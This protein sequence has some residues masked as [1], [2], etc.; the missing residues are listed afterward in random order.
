MATDSNEI[1]PAAGKMRAIVQDHYGETAEVLRLE[2]IDRPQIGDDDVLVRVRAASVHIGDWH[3]MSGL[4]YLLRVVGFGFRAPKVRVRGMDLAGTVEAVGHNVTRFQAGDEVFGTSNGSFAEYASASEDTLALKPANLTFQQAAAVPTS[5]VAA[6]QALRDAGGIKADQ[7]VLLVGASG[8]VGLFA[9]QIAKSFGAEVTGVCSTTKV[10]LVRSLGA[11][12][13]IDH[14]QEDFTQSGQQY[15][16]ILVMGGN[17]SLSQ[18]KRVLR[19]GGTLV[20][21]GTEE[22]NRWV[23]GKAWIQA[24]LLS[25]LKRHLR[26][27]ASE[28]N[29]ADLQFVTELI[30]AGKIAPVIDRT[31]PLSEVPDAIRYLHAGKARGKIA[32][33]V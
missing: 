7:Q 23:G 10:D 16:L 2:E 17:Q 31:F 8:G 28:P 19:P 30:E 1:R 32:I 33:T 22:G 25:R 9:V 6:L 11:D 20:P 3:V 26:P 12:H 4:P 18:L 5:A 13:V 29:Q 21:V 27:L 24:M 14:T 15:D